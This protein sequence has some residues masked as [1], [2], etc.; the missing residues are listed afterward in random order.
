MGVAAFS[1]GYSPNYLLPIYANAAMVALV[2]FSIRAL[3]WLA[4]NRPERPLSRVRGGVSFTVDR[5]ALYFS[6][7]LFF[8]C[9]PPIK[10]LIPKAHGFFADPILASL[11]RAIFGRDVWQVAHLVPLIKA[12]DLGYTLWPLTIMIG[13]LWIAVTADREN[14]RRFF[15]GWAISFWLLGAA[16]AMLLASAGPI[17]APDLGLGFA[18]LHPALEGAKYA[19]Y[20]HDMLWHV[21][22]TNAVRIGGGISAAP[23]M[24]CA[25]TFLFVLA[26]RR[27]SLFPPALAY[28]AF[29][30]FGSIYLGWHYA[31]DG[32][33]S[34]A[35]V[36]L[37]W[38]S[39]NP[40]RSPHGLGSSK[41]H[42]TDPPS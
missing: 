42:R 2:F 30:Y 29:I 1:T 17:F 8:V 41:D 39:L 3:V 33:V 31:S 19:M 25:L 4:I 6:S 18:G 34:F 7:I 13:A 27:T 5:A 37:I 23:S 35:G 38:R 32:L 12:I 20:I 28:L 26:V 9:L 11:D 10:M 15:L 21:Y 40:V 14:L 16:L 22:T 36:A 24:H